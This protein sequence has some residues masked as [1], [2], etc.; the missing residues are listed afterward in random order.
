MYL[1]AGTKICDVFSNGVLLS[2]SSE[3]PTALAKPKFWGNPWYFLIGEISYHGL[4][5]LF[6]VMWLEFGQNQL[7]SLGNFPEPLLSALTKE[8]FFFLVDHWLNV[9]WNT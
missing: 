6:I 4:E 7:G 2:A 3:C 1:C 8:G 9:K 5:F